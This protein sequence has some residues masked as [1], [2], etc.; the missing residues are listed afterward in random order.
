MISRAWFCQCPTSD[1]LYS[2]SIRI[3]ISEK[4]VDDP[5]DFPSRKD[6]N[7]RENHYS[8]GF[9]DEEQLRKLRDDINNLI[10]YDE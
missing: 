4:L 9:F 7:I 5:I 3:P 8:I 6:P 1:M 2:L 10:G